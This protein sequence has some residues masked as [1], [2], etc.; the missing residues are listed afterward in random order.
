M[1]YLLEQFQN[2]GENMFTGL[3]QK[4]GRLISLEKKPEGATIIVA[5]D[6]WDESLVPGESIAVNG[7]CLTVVDVREGSFTA[8]VLSKTLAITNLCDKKSGA[9]LNLERALRVGDRYGGHMISG[10]IDGVG[11]V[12]A[13]RTAGRDHV[14][15]IKCH[16]D[17]M[18][19]IVSKGSFACDGVSLTV[20]TVKQ[21]MFSFEVNII[22]YTWEHSNLSD[23]RIGSAVNLETDIM[24]KYVRKYMESHKSYDGVDFDALTKAGFV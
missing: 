16:V 6:A 7:I 1:I 18:A 20:S 9:L 19:G 4:V 2:A 21:D 10:H 24:G 12:S 8:D 14:V 3:I 15:E 23:W 17:I 5:L 22:P 13:L 11:K